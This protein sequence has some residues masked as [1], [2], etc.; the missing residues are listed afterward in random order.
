M[1]GCD[2][3]IEP[4]PHNVGKKASWVPQ[5]PHPRVDQSEAG[6]EDVEV[7]L[8]AQDGTQRSEGF[9]VVEINLGVAGVLHE[10]VYTASKDQAHAVYMT[11]RRVLVAREGTSAR[12]QR[13]CKIADK[14]TK[15]MI[16][17]TCRETA[18][19]RKIFPSACS[20]CINN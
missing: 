11:G 15:T 6:L 16:K 10:S 20:E 2:V 4:N 12:M 17:M 7:N 5:V 19:M 3:E 14:A 9:G 18:V 13:R 1:H 8:V